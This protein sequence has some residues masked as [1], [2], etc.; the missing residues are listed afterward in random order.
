MLVFRLNPVGVWLALLLIGLSAGGSIAAMTNEALRESFA[1]SGV[2]YSPY[3]IAWHLQ[4]ASVRG[5]F[6]VSAYAIPAA[7]YV[8]YVRRILREMSAAGAGESAAD[9]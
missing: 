7:L 6:A 8:L 3:E 9:R 1:P 5:M 2:R 4:L